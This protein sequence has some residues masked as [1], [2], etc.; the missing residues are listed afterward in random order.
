VNSP[1]CKRS[2]RTHMA[3]TRSVSSPCCL[4]TPTD[5]R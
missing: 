1:C 2:I 5:T 4:Y 3:L